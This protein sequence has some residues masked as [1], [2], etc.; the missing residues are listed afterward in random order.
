MV[1]RGESIFERFRRFQQVQVVEVETSVRIGSLQPARLEISDE[2][3]NFAAARPRRLRALA[4][5]VCGLESRSFR[6]VWCFVV[7]VCFL[8]VIGF[9][10]YFLQNRENWLLCF[11]RAIWRIK[12]YCFLSFYKLTSVHVVLPKVKTLWIILQN[13]L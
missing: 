10:K 4:I 13:G 9:K 1:K 5:F 7:I 8:C 12:V 11:N 3:F 2:V 6:F